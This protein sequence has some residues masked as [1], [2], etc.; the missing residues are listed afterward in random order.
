[1][2]Q[3]S[4]RTYWTRPSFSTLGYQ[5]ESWSYVRRMIAFVAGSRRYMFVMR[6]RPDSHG[7][8]CSAASDVKTTLSSGR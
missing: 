4:H 5:S 8:P 3:Y 2:S 7:R 1:M 6:Q